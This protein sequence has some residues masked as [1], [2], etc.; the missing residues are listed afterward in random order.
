MA[1]IIHHT[2]GF[3][4]TAT[5]DDMNFQQ[6]FFFFFFSVNTTHGIHTYVSVQYVL[7]S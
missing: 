3:R 4:Y 6:F 7:S 5:E 1:H 2:A